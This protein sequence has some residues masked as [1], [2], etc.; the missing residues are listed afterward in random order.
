MTVEE[1]IEDIRQRPGFE[2]YPECNRATG[3][4]SA[5]WSYMCI[6][7]TEC[8]RCKMPEKRWTLNEAGLCG[9]CAFDLRNGTATGSLGQPYFHEKG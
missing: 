3:N 5:P 8:R 6:C 4:S 2:G 7:Q 1:Q 9:N